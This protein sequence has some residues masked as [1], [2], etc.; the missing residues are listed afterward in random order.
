MENH[1]SIPKQRIMVQA[2]AWILPKYFDGFPKDSDFELKVEQLPEPKDGEILLEAV[3]LS[4]DPYMRPFSRVRMKEGDVMIGAQVAKVVQSRNPLF[5][6]GSHVISRSG[7]RT[8]TVSDGTGVILLLSDWPA[9]VPYSLALGA[10]G[11]P[12]LTALYGLEEVCQ[13][14]AGETLLVN[15]AAGAVG[16]VVGQIAKLKGCRVIGSAGSDAKVAYLKELGFDQAFNYKTVQSLEQAL[17]EA[18]P[19]GYDCYFENVGG[20]FSSVAIPLMKPMGRI[21]VCGAISTYND[22]T[23]QTGP[24]PHLTMIMN[25]IRMEGFLVGRWEHKNKESLRRLLVWKQ[26]GKLKCPEH[27]TSGFENMPAAFMGMLRGENLG[28]AVV[29]A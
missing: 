17:R 8:H 21:A 26:E 15:A 5:P 4:V 19:E 6:E 20:A 12:G 28:K 2:K 22:T 25:Q 9:D 23:P 27:V 10:I 11:M 3:Y 1:A 18:A 16:M 7:W 14:K 13:L 24:F 29:K